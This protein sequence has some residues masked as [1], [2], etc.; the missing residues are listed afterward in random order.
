VSEEYINMHT[1]DQ[2]EKFI[3][4]LEEHGKWIKA[5]VIGERLGKQFTPRLLR[6]IAHDHPQ[7]ISSSKGYI[8]YDHATDEEVMHNIASLYSSSASLKDRA[9]RLNHYHRVEGRGKIV[10]LKGWGI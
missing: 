6:S 2:A 9:S 5:K 3:K 8:H 7:V 1:K 4:F 10:K